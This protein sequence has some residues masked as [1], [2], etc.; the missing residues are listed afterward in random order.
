[1]TTFYLSHHGIKGQRKGIQNGPPYPLNRETHNRVVNSGESKNYGS[2]KLVDNIDSASHASVSRY[3]TDRA[4]GVNPNH[5]N[6]NCKE[7]NGIPY[8]H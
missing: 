6:D 8:N 3:V 2:N 1:M 7:V 5:Y 4:S